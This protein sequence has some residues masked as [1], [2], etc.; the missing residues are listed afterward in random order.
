MTIKF[1]PDKTAV[2]FSSMVVRHTRPEFQQR[3][4]GEFFLP[5]I[6]EVDGRIHELPVVAAYKH[7]GGVVTLNCS[8]APDLFFRYSQAAGIVK[9]LSTKLFSSHRFDLSVRRSLLRALYCLQV[10]AH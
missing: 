6:D 7:L 5:I 10:C 2:L 1:G 8:P 4:D 9:P 3:P